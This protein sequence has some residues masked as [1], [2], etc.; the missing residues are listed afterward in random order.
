MRREYGGLGIPSL[1][2]LNICLLASWIKRY[3]S[4]S[5]KLWKEVIDFKYRIDKPNIFCTNDSKAS[6]FFKGFMWAAKAANMGYRWKIGNGQKAKF[7]E[8]IWLGSSSLAIQFWE[9][10]VIVKNRNG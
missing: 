4:R 8:D 10:Y 7:W 3:Q 5:G 6:P 1:R 9:L 2:D